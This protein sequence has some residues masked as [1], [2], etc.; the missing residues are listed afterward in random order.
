LH[1]GQSNVYES[2]LLKSFKGVPIFFS[3][4]DFIYFFEKE[5]VSERERRSRGRE[6]QTP[7]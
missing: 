2:S 4:K 7:Q 5:R 3:F 6:K 1:F